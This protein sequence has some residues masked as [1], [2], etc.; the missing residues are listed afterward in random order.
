MTVPHEFTIRPLEKSD[1]QTLK[2]LRLE[3]LRSEPHVFSRRYDDEA[4]RSDEEWQQIASNEN[5]GQQV[6]GL[7]AADE[8]I[9]I[10]AIFTDRED[11]TGKTAVLAMSYLK[12]CYRRRGLSNLLYQARLDWART[13]GTFASI[14]VSHRLS[15]AASRQANQRHGFTEI[16]SVDRMW[17]DGT[18]EPEVFYQLTLDS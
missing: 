10:T 18:A 17:P 2:L 1:W 9:G 11:P 6:F 8:M 15:N 16:T 14:R 7:F 4:G 13:Q 12:P 5:A 3:A